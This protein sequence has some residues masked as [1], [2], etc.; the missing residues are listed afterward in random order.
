MVTNVETKIAEQ[1][2][3]FSMESVCC[4]CV[5]DRCVQC[6]DGIV[7]PIVKLIMKMIDMYF[8]AVKRRR[9]CGRQHDRGT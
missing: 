4:P 6:T 1:I 9:K 8:L 2:Q 7:V 5:R 3:S